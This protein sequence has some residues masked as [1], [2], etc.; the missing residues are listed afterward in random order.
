MAINNSIMNAKNFYDKRTLEN[1]D[2]ESF[3][4]KDTAKRR[5]GKAAVKSTAIT[6][7]NRAKGAVLF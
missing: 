7:Y 2:S 6:D 1:S 5:R 4:F 3:D